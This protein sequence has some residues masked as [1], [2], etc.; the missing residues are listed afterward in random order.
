[1]RVELIDYTREPL[2]VLAMSTLVSYWDEWSIDKL[3]KITEKDAEIHLPRVLGYGHESILEH[4]KLTWAVEGISRV[5]SHQLVRHRLASYTQRSQRYIKEDGMR[6]VIPES[7]KQ[8][9]WDT[10][11]EDLILR[12]QS[13]YD[14][15]ILAGVPPED[16]RYILPQAVTTSIVVTMNFR[17]F[18]HFA[19][20]RLCQR[21]QWEIRELAWRMWE[22]VY[23]IPELRKLLIWAKVGPKCIQ[24]GYCPEKELAPENCYMKQMKWWKRIKDETA[25]LR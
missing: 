14:D 13:L 2:R 19:G 3:D 25:E 17:E 15:L 16:A 1:M 4:I 11:F 22:E 23:K 21:A 12:A 10:M 7:V 24:L 20:L 9:G 5:T 8:K 18:K 6:F